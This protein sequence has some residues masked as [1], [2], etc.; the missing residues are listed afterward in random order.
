MFK[1]ISIFVFLVMVITSCRAGKPALENLSSGMRADNIAATNFSE[2]STWLL[3]YIQL[4]QFTAMPHAQWY[5]TGFNSYVPAGS[6][7]EKLKAI[8]QE[9][10]SITIILGTWCPD[11][12]REV[13]RFMKVLEQ[14]GFPAGRVTFI[15]VDNNKIAPVGG[16]EEYGIERVPTFIIMKNKIETGRIIENPVTSLE[17][18]LLNILTDDENKVNR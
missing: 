18:D 17:Q 16:Y 12:R 10:L 6:V 4:F 9:G 14:W 13:P 11:S 2:P 8:E 7:V 3:G 15:G 5:S 1:N